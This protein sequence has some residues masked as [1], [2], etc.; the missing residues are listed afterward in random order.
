MAYIEYVS[1]PEWHLDSDNILRV[2]GIHPAVLR[3]HYDLYK[4]TMFSSSP[5]SRTRREMIAVVVS[6]VNGCH[7]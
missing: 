4:A 7:Y 5:L 6:A 2:H 1:A 3:A